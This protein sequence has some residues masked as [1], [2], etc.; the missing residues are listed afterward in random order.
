MMRALHIMAGL[1]ALV[2]GALALFALKGGALHRGSGRVFVY[3]MVAMGGSGALMAALQ[4]EVAYVNVIA[5]TLTC[6]LVVTA[7]LTVR[8]PVLEFHWIDAGAMLVALAAG[9]FALVLGLEASGSAKGTK[10]G[11]PAGIYFMFAAV[12]LLA[13]FGDARVRLGRRIEGPRRLARHLW[14]MCFALYVATASFFLGQAQVFP[15]PVRSSGLLFVPVLTVVVVFIYWL[16]RVW[17]MQRRQGGS[18]R[19][20]ALQ[21]DLSMRTRLS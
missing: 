18:G 10:D 4:P 11:I 9:L 19:G 8:R 21:P 2:S 5:G 1:S 16:A 17:R 15:K 7:L 13:T 6:Y 20:R 3:T 14:R 12:A